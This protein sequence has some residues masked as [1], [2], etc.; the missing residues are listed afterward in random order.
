MK[1][2]KLIV[3]AFL[4]AQRD[5]PTQPLSSMV[6][7]FNPQSLR[8]TSSVNYSSTQGINSSGRTQQYNFT[9]PRQVSFKLLFDGNGP[10]H[11]ELA[12][13][14]TS[15]DKLIE[16]FQVLTSQYNGEIHQPNFLVINWGGL[17]FNCR[18]ARLD[19]NYTLFDAQGK[20]LS[21]ELDCTFIGDESRQT[22]LLQENKQSPDMTHIRYIEAASD[23]TL[24]A[25]EIYDCP[26][27]YLALAKFNR[28]ND[29][30]N[31]SYGQKIICPPVGEL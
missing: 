31:L 3:R 10:M 7:M 23:L 1:L 14:D 12:L 20:V 5:Q 26:S 4:N 17:D 9:P 27:Y 25:N 13:K 18:L 22:L 29:F 24:I 2:Q 11:F 15:I 8:Q 16:Q 30:R 28:L 19:I 6:A 21:A